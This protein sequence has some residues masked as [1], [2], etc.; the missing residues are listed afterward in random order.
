LRA[1]IE[2]AVDGVIIIDAAG[3]VQLYNPACERIFG[4]RAEEVLG[5]KVNMLMPSPYREEH[6]GYIARYRRTGEARIIGIG[7]EVEGR[8]KDGSIFPM[9]L[10]V[11]EARQDG[12][13]VFV[14]MIRDISER[15]ETQ[16]RM[17]EMQREL[18]HV[19]RLSAM[20]EM[21][22]TLA[23][24]LNQP[25]T[26]VMNYVQAA[27]RMLEARERFAPERIGETMEKAVEQAGR[28]GQIIRRL[29][30][31]IRK[32]ETE[33]AAADANQIVREASMLGLVGA[34]E[35]GVAVRFDLTAELP[36]VLIDPIQVQQVVLNL[37]RNSMDALAQAERREITVRTGLG[38]DGF[39]EVAVTDTG[40]GLAQEVRDRLFEPFLT[41]KA[42]GMGIGLSISRSII[43]SH[44]GE[45]RAEPNPGGGVS[46]RFTLPV[47]AEGKDRNGA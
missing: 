45:L 33:K 17:A 43:D 18:V 24:E 2:T 40:P 42:G 35:A 4:Y 8:R 31:F 13:S 38:G 37:V 14:G 19:S 11:G 5:Q 12:E 44:G 29:R 15:H 39:V 3:I 20:G 36:P 47:A 21:A 6:D 7:R 41:T 10:A 27:R 46:F 25:L 28:A 32:G 30:E 34:R 16:R 22:S 23:H 9:D 1:V 26:A